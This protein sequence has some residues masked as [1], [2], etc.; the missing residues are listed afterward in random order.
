MSD[1]LD[2]NTPAAKRL[3]EDLDPDWDVWR[4]I[5]KDTVHRLRLR[6]RRRV[7]CRRRGHQWRLLR[8]SYI[9]PDDGVRPYRLCEHCR[10][11]EENPHG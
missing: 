9:G 4:W 5:V 8:A 1:F 7:T 2:P 10:L 3:R 6:F 11:V